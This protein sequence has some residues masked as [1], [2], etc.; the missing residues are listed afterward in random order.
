MYPYTL[1]T[2]IPKP[3]YSHHLSVD[4]IVSV[5]I[6][7]PLP[8]SIFG[9]KIPF[10]TKHRPFEIRYI[11]QRRYFNIYTETPETPRVEISECGELLC[12]GDDREFTPPT[13]G[14]CLDVLELAPDGRRSNFSLEIYSYDVSTS[15]V[16]GRGAFCVTS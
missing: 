10:I 5:D 8:L 14:L 12:F 16:A 15:E 1:P 13:R 3:T 11:T 6:G 7:R 4:F 2:V 9:V